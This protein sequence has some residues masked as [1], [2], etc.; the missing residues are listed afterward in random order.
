MQDQE[1]M[2]VEFVGK[3]STLL[4]EVPEYS[5]FFLSSKTSTY[6]DLNPGP[7]DNFK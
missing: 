6:F 3:N 2:W 4:R 7:N 5:G 1:P